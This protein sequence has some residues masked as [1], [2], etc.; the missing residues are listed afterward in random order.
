LVTADDAV[1]CLS[2]IDLNEA[3]QSEVAKSQD[4]LK[5]LGCLRVGSGIRVT[6]MGGQEGKSPWHVRLYPI[7]IS[8]GV[9]LWG[10]PYSFTA[11]DGTK[12]VP[13]VQARRR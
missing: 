2:P 4:L 13:V 12:L 5:K 6:M 1:L 9:A 10:F 11:A 7:G 8:G 3:T